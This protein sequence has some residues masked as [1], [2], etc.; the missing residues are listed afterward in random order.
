M[1]LYQPLRAAPLETIRTAILRKSRDQ[2]PHDAVAYKAA[3]EI[4]G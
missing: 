1:N 2:R 3:L 4:L